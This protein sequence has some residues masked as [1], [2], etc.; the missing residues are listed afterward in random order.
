MK[1]AL[2]L[3]AL[4]VLLTAAYGWWNQRQRMAEA[5]AIWTAI[6]AGAATEG[7]VFDPQMVA[8][9]PE[10]ARRYF[11]RAIRP[12][13]PLARVATLEMRGT[14]LLGGG[15][16]AT[17]LA[18]EAEQIL[19]PPAAF[20][21]RARMQGLGMRI[22]GSDGLWQGRGWTRFWLFRTIPLV[23]AAGQAD[24][25]RSAAARPAI[26]AVW[27]PATLLPQNGARWRQT[28]P[29][30]A[31]VRFDEGPEEPILL[32]IDA[33][34]RL[35][36]AET[37]RWSDANPEEVFRL[38]PFGGTFASEA[39]FGGFTIPAEVEVGNMFGTVDHAPFFRARIV[40]A[41]FR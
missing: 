15:A 22:S 21:W 3:L 2:G 34:G 31:E 23:Q 35:R 10:I 16:D 11:A 14:F 32:T 37:L 19:A 9:Q 40:A 1:T 39:T 33:D 8:D 24:F 6:A 30:T 20:V 36:A 28:G 26:E 29:E 18:M 25:D 12:G 17:E 27:V 7:A 13:T 38:Q 4:V 5:G 41:E